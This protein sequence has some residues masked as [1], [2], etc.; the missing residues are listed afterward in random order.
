MQSNDSLKI[1]ESYSYFPMLNNHES[2]YIIPHKMN[3]N[4]NFWKY[5]HLSEKYYCSE[6]SKNLSLHVKNFFNT[7]LVIWRYLYIKTIADSEKCRICEEKLPINEFFFHAKYCMEK[8]VYCKGLIDI[9]GKMKR[10]IDKLNQYKETQDEVEDI[11]HKKVGKIAPFPGLI[12]GK[13]DRFKSKSEDKDFLNKCIEKMPEIPENPEKGDDILEEVNNKKIIQEFIKS[14]KSLEQ[15]TNQHRFGI[16]KAIKRKSISEELELSMSN[17][18]KREAADYIDYFIAVFKNEI[19]QTHKSYEK[20]PYKLKTLNISIHL[21][22]KLI[23]DQTIINEKNEKLC[24]IYFE[25]LYVLVSKEK[26]MEMLLFDNIEQDH[27]KSSSSSKLSNLNKKRFWLFKSDN[28]VSAMNKKK[29]VSL[30]S[31][32]NMKDIFKTHTPKLKTRSLNSFKPDSPSKFRNRASFFKKLDLRFDKEEDKYKIDQNM[33]KFEDGTSARKLGKNRTNQNQIQSDEEEPNLGSGGLPGTII[34][35]LND[36][37]CTYPNIEK[38]YE[39][40]FESL[41]KKKISRNKILIENM[42]K[43]DN[44]SNFIYKYSLVVDQNQSFDNFSERDQ[45][46]PHISI[47]DASELNLNFDSDTDEISKQ[48]RNIEDQ[49]ANQGKIS[50]LLIYKGTNLNLTNNSINMFGSNNVNYNIMKPKSLLKDIMV[51]DSSCEISVQS[52]SSFTDEKPEDDD[53]NSYFE[54][55]DKK[56][57]GESEGADRMIS[58]TFSNGSEHTNTE[59]MQNIIKSFKKVEQ[60]EKNQNLYNI[61]DP[62]PNNVN[63]YDSEGGNEDTIQ[64]QQVRLSDFEI[65]V[66]LGKGA[67]GKVDLVKKITTGDI[68]ALK[69]VEI[70]ENVRIHLNTLELQRPSKAP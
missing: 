29:K 63:D 67:F 27:I 54:E 65:I 50:Y 53:E 37:E 51:N 41:V 2:D 22:S 16:K 35:Q 5:L 23:V 32:N 10:C 13:R 4:E 3:L 26:V 58:Q 24:E 1:Y 34:T 40:E 33:L 17:K 43:N 56:Y 38:M 64:I 68:Y 55:I 60:I 25:L 15:L 61:D 39:N 18:G 44:F 42:N 21:L 49:I 31:T 28:L 11:N 8:K 70:R 62:N 66:T 9:K 57:D 19:K 36:A 48:L 14:D 20:I 46:H 45:N 6:K 47:K 59:E 30:K 7:K 69:T 12:K 52:D